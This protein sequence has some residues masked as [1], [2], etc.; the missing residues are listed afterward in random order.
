MTEASV[1][2]AAWWPAAPKWVAVEAVV[3]VA[4]AV[5]V[6]AAAAAVVAVVAAAAVV[7]VD[8]VDVV[9]DGVV[10]AAAAAAVV[11]DGDA[12]ADAAAAQPQII[13][14]TNG[15]FSN[16]D[17]IGFLVETNEWN[18][19]DDGLKVGHHLLRDASMLLLL[20]RREHLLRLQCDGD[21]R[22][23]RRVRG[24]RRRWQRG[25]YCHQ[26]PTPESKTFYN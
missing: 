3:A 14:I 24:R 6:V 4:V 26:R 11:V 12:A 20:D 7:D 17:E 25:R 1:P 15:L 13:A 16:H 10:V 2:D 18:L 9:V 5:V 22:R 8:V 19:L 23:H 21:G